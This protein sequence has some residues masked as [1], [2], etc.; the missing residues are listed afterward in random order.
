MKLVQFLGYKGS[1]KTRAV[2]YVA[3]AL[4]RRGFRVGTVKHIHDASFTMDTEGKD[5]WVHAKSGAQV[6]AA[7]APRELAVIMK[8]DTGKLKAERLIG[9]FRDA[10]IDYVLI[11]GYTSGFTRGSSPLRIVCARSKDDAV[12][13]M[14]IHGKP[15]CVI[16]KVDDSSNLER[17]GTPVLQLP[18]DTPK[19][20]RL[21][22]D[23]PVP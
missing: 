10:G 8:M 4:T 20:I 6:V 14:R 21:L 11:E 2:S 23:P 16:G 9:I 22:G 1:G 12:E 3:R 13:L 5:T 17:G 7:V 18:K 15:L 19:V